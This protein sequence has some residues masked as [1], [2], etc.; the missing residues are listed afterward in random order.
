MAILIAE[1]IM[2]SPYTQL[3]I[4]LV[5]GTW[6]RLPLINEHNQNRIYADI[7]AEC[8]KLK[9]KPIIVGG[10]SD[11]VHLLVRFHQTVTIA[12]LVKQVKGASSH[13]ATHKIQKDVF[14]K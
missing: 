14:F 12:G 11:H 5:W 13:L 7:F 6:D 3:Y 8:E 2:R 1:L 4:H 9:C 10:V